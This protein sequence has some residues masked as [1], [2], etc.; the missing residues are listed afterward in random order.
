MKKLCALLSLLLCLIALCVTA[1]AEQAQLPR[2]MLNSNGIT[3][4]QDIL[5]LDDKTVKLQITVTYEEGGAQF[6][7]P[8]TVKIQGTSSIYYPKKNYYIEFYSDSSFHTKQKADLLHGWGAHSKYCLKANW[9]DS[10]HSRNVVSGRLAGQMQAEFGNLFPEAVNH[11]VVDGYPVEVYIDGE[12]H[13]LYTLNIPKEDWLFG[14]DEDAGH[15]VLG[16]ENPM[17][18]SSTYFRAF[19][20]AVHEADWSI[21]VG[22]HKT[23]EEVDAA[24]EKLNR[25]INFVKDST[26]EEFVVQFDK[27]LNLDACL[28]YFCLLELFTGTDNCA[29]NLMLVTYDGELWYPCMYDM[30][31]TWGLWFSG[32]GCY[33]A[34]V[35]FENVHNNSLLWT[36][37]L[38]CFPQEIQTRYF[39]LRSSVLSNANIQAAFDAFQAEVPADA[40]EREKEKW[41]DVPS[42]D[43]GFDQ[44]KSNIVARG[45]FTDVKM[46]ELHHDAPDGMLYELPISLNGLA[47]AAMDTGLNL[48]DGV[49][50]DFTLFLQFQCNPEA[51]GLQTI[52]SNQ[53][54]DGNGLIIHTDPEGG[55]KYLMYYCGNHQY[56]AHYLDGENPRITLAVTR[57]GDDYSIYCQDISQMR[58][59]KSAPV[60]AAVESNMYLGGQHYI[61]DDTNIE[62]NLF[63][64]SI[65]HAEVYDKVLREEEISTRINQLRSLDT[66][67]EPSSTEASGI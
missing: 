8:A 21:E 58:H 20:P 13:G 4:N 12:Y 56:E 6:T 62:F 50:G 39:E 57:Q 33:P 2:V 18:D 38:T 41:P 7:C 49:C 37:L 30:D 3:E 65:F 31:S 14:V 59:I 16:A 23:Q 55:S 32:E 51:E 10:T 19:A 5:A 28:N 54:A 9:I 67:S 53:D 48:F 17:Q 25:L 34:T 11:G 52:L 40:W 36:R 44:I 42:R 22:P 1:S 45:A 26:D 60:S 64:G 66:V 24:F 47:G 29:K 27:H 43:I 63:T 61:Q 15:L 35:T 46:L